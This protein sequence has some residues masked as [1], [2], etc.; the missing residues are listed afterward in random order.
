[1]PN[2]VGATRWFYGSGISNPPV[3]TRAPSTYLG[4]MHVRLGLRS[5]A[6][7]FAIGLLAVAGVM[8]ISTGTAL[9]GTVTGTVAVPTGY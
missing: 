9:A 4:R 8:G 3:D 7:R 5:L 6:G 2:S 1:M